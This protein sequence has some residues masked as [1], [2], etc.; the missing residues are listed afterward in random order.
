VSFHRAATVIRDRT[1]FAK[2]R[3]RPVLRFATR[4]VVRKLRAAMLRAA[5]LSAAML[6]AWHRVLGSRFLLSD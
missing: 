5:M 4:A 3:R 6:S 1:S 2:P